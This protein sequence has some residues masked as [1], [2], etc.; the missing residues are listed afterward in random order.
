MEGTL[1]EFLAKQMERKMQLEPWIDQIGIRIPIRQ[2]NTQ[3]RK[4][5]G[6]ES[7]RDKRIKQIPSADAINKAR[8]MS[9]NI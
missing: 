4:D 6:E 3:G 8:T 9:R 7:K 2:R 5:W 1:P